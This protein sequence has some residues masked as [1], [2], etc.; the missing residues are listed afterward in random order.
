MTNLLKS[1]WPRRNW[2]MRQMLAKGDAAKGD[3]ATL[4]PVSFIHRTLHALFG[5]QVVALERQQ[6]PQPFESEQTR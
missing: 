5:K 4:R 6:L 2:A 3:D 1:Q